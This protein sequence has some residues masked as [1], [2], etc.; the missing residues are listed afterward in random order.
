MRKILW[1]LMLACFVALPGAS[2]NAAARDNPELQM[3]KQRHKQERK[4]LKMRQHFQ[5]ESMKGQIISSAV[6]AQMKHQMEREERELRERQKDQ[7][8]DL[9]D[10]MRLY[11]ESMKQMGQ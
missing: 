7:M 9:K 6:R 5:K 4:D 8:Q 3:L 1:L 2:V 10:Q 11:R